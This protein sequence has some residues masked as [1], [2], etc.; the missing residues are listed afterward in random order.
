MK[1]VLYE[2]LKE[3]QNDTTH[4]TVNTKGMTREEWL[5]ERRTGIGGSDAGAVMGMN[6]WATPM[7]VFFAKKGESA[8]EGNAAT[9]RGARMEG[10]IRSWIK[11]DNPS[12]TVEEVP[13]MYKRQATVKTAGGEV[14][15]S[16]LA[17]LDGLICAPKAEGE[18]KADAIQVMNGTKEAG[19]AME[20]G[21]LWGLEIKTSKYGED[22]LDDAIPDSY[23]CQVQH[24]MAV[25][26]LKGFLLVAFVT[27][28]DEVRFYHIPQNEN[29]IE[30]LLTK[31]ADLWKKVEDDELPEPVGTDCE[32][33]ALSAV[34]AKRGVEKGEVLQLSDGTLETLQELE[35]VK[36]TMAE[37]KEKETALKEKVKVELL[38]LTKEGNEDNGIKATCGN[39][40][41]AWIVSNRTS[42]DAD[43]MK[44]DGIFEK[45]SKV[46]TTK[47]MRITKSKK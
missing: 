45:Y 9:E 46:S 14:K 33:E 34:L 12:L 26:G 2:L 15:L 16:M 29:F 11:A 5:C 47:S 39:Y 32:D 35:E 3:Q 6:K 42:A 44:E 19:V 17:N 7:T 22:F 41:I 38:S 36:D 21:D 27:S 13:V 28:T 4:T 37:L 1:K 31:E 18:A 8:F 40:K 43:K 20:R 24:Y 10:V 23:Y 30:T 25:T